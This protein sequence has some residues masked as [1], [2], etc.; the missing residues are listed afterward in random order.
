[1]EPKG[2]TIFNGGIV[3]VR[4]Y[5]EKGYTPIPPA[6]LNDQ[7]YA[8]GLQ[9]F[10]PACTDVAII[11]QKER[12]LYLARR[13][14]KP[15]TGWWWMG[16]SIIAKETPIESAIRCFR[17]ETTLTLS[18]E[19]LVLRAVNTYLWKDREQ[20]PRDIGCH[21]AD[22]VFTVELPEAMVSSIVLEKN[23]FEAEKGFTPFRRNVLVREEVF[24]AI[25]DLYDTVFPP[26]Q[27]P[28]FGR[29]A[30]A[31]E[32]ERRKIEEFNSDSFS[33]QMFDIKSSNMPLMPLGKH[34]HSR[35]FE[36]FTILEGSG[37][38]LTCNIDPAENNQGVATRMSLERGSVVCLPPHVAHTFYL[39]SG[40]KMHCFSSRAFDQTDFIQCPFLV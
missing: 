22:W 34:A 17:R 7:E 25:L 8:L 2:I 5:A 40:S 19:D 9:R 24:P 12:T 38:L 36:V 4:S 3:P 6:R 29:V 18:A 20:E 33:V 1:M 10:V 30:L 13:R 14:S 35:K 27:P 26:V 21:M 28:T 32:D 39:T 11:N 37:E 23:E 15:M 31:H 16:G